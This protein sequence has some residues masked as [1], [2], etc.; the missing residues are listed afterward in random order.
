MNEEDRRRFHRIQFDAPA[1]LLC[2]GKKVE[3]LVLDCSLKGVLVKSQ[4]GWSPEIG[5]GVVLEL[6]LAE[7]DELIR[8]ETE[9]SRVS[10]DS[11]G[12]NCTHI[13]LDSIIRLRRLV[14]LNL[15]NPELLERDLEHLIGD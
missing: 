3:T 12:L 5:T 7:H 10:D 8:M 1:L 9:I 4:P 2:A 13:D 15:G 6:R 14:E 11:V